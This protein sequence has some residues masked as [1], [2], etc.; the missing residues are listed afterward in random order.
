MGANISTHK[1]P[2]SSKQNPPKSLDQ[3]LT[4]Q[5]SHAEF[6]SHKHVKKAL[7]YITNIRNVGS[8][9][10]KNPY[11]KKNFP[12]QNNLQIENC[13]PKNI[14]RSS[15]SLEIQSTPLPFPPLGYSP[16][17]IFFWLS[18]CQ[19]LR[20]YIQ[21]ERI[22]TSEAKIRR[23]QLN[24]FPPPSRSLEQATFGYVNKAKGCLV[25]KFEFF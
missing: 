23:A 25:F 17:Q 15:L 7:N 2:Q 18:L 10:P 20:Q 19:A 21:W 4:L 24:D 5:K 16:S 11:F 9:Y 22:K 13:K 14:L 8:E 12:T 3:N 6:P 1:N